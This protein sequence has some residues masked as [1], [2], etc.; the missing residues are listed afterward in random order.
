M[1]AAAAT[2]HRPSAVLSCL[3]GN[4]RETM[5]S[6]SD[7]IMPLPTPCNAREKIRNSSTVARPQHHDP[8]VNRIMPSTYIR[9]LP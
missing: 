3:A 8:N 7:W 2:A 6:P 4:S 1:D 5:A 9:L